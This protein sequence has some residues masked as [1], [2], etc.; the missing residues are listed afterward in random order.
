[1]NVQFVE[2]GGQIIAMLPVADYERL[3]DMAEN[4]ADIAAAQRA[5][6]R[7]LEGEE[8]VPFALIDSIIKGENALRAWRKFRG[9]TLSQL[10]NKTNSRQA[11]LS[12]IENGK[13]HGKPALWR[14]LAE[15][16]NVS[17]DDILP[18]C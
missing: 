3:L 11:M 6:K 4:N 2:V 12:D 10:A 14:A 15:T 8:Y 17:V 1:M 5:E 16:L 7:R 9:L 13:A 18:D